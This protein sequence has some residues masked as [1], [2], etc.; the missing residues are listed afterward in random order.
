MSSPENL[1][2]ALNH[3]D[4]LPAIPSIAQ[5]ILSLKI[6]TDEGE[7]AL[8]ELVGKDP[9]ILSRIVGLAN[10]PLFGTGRDILT[11]REAVALLGSRRIKMVAISFSMMTSMARKHVGLL[12]IQSLWQHSLSIAMTMDYMARLMPENLRPSD[13]EIYL[14][15]LLHDIG[16][17]VLDYLDTQL[18]DRFH[19]RMAAEPGRTVEEI[20]AKMLEMNHGELGAALAQCWGLPEIIVAVINY[21][22]RPD[23]RRADVGQPLV[24]MTNLAEKLLPPFGISE[25]VQPQISAEEWRALGIDPRRE[26]EI[27]AAVKENIREVSDMFLQRI[28]GQHE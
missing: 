16:F 28:I 27:V 3:L 19:A 11:L 2:Q 21:H 5:K 4:S 22:H 9:T 12:D 10:S 20:E 14:A 23:D 17:L 24:T 8:L 15:G 7:R 1:R 18:S 25:P 26:S 13:D 6:T